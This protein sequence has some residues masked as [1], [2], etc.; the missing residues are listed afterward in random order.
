MRVVK[1]LN[2]VNPDSQ[3]SWEFDLAPGAEKVLTYQYKVLI[4]R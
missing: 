2:S 1:R 3:V 4:Y